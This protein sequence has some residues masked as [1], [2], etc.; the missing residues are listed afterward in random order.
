MAAPPSSYG[1]R[2]PLQG[3]RRSFTAPS[4]QLSL[5]ERAGL[6]KSDADAEI[7]YSHP[8]ARIIAFS[9]P[10]DAIQSQ[11]KETLPDAD[12]PIDAVEILPWRSRNET[13]YSSGAIK[14]EKVRG[15]SHFLK[16]ADQKVIQGLMRNSQCW[17]VDGES[18]FVLR[19]GQLKY[20]RIEL[21]S[22]AEEDK[23]K[24]EEFKA[25]LG[26]VLRFERTPCP[27]KRGFHVDLPDDAITPRRKGTWKRR[28]PLQPTTPNTDPLPLRRTK[29]SRAW[30]FQAKNDSSPLQPS[31]PT[32][33][34]LWSNRES[35]FVE[36]PTRSHRVPFVY[37]I[38]YHFQRR[39][40][41]NEAGRRIG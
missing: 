17:C 30:S 29:N 9:P 14:I 13:L 34:R 18:K 28:Q 25:A 16:S 19:T 22:E 37:A 21:P 23:Q 41:R 15:S 31:D 3:W 40:V 2:P 35:R 32:R 5:H 27:F 7:L 33:I 12:Y 38:Q 36:V 4:R 1:E 20:Y 24:V 8:N 6:D 26:K 10:T 39:R 11:S